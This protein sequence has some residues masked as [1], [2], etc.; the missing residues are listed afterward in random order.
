MR[1]LFFVSC[2]SRSALALAGLALLAGPAAAA[3]PVS[4][5]EATVLELRRALDSGATTSVEIVRESLLRIALYEDRLNAVIAVNPEALEEAAARD[6]ERAELAAAGRPVPLLHG[7]PVALKDNIHTLDL[8]TTGGALAFAGLVPPYEATL[9]ANLRAAGAIVLAKT[10]MTE[11]A[12]WIAAGMPTNYCALTGFGFNPYDPRRDPRE[13]TADGRPALWTGGSSSGVGTAVSFWVASVGTETSGS[14]LSP[15]GQ[16]L[17]AAVKPTVGRVSRYGIIPLTADQDTAG[18][19]ARTVTDAAI[20]LSALEG[21]APDPH[22]AET[23]RCPRP[24]GGDYTRFLDAGAL[25]GARIGIPR[26]Y[27][28]DEVTPPGE[29]EAIGGL[30]EGEAA[31]MKEAIEVLRALGAEVVDP[32]DIPSVV[33]ADRD[34]NALLWSVCRGPGQGKGRDADCSIVFKYGMKRDF[35]AWLASLGERAP[36][37][38]L[39]ALRQ[40]NVAH[41][42]MGAL[43]YGQAQLD[44]SDEMDVAL[45]RARYEMDRAKDLRLSRDEGIDAALAAHRLDALLFPDGTGAA[46]AAKAGYPTVMVPMGFVPNAPAPPFPPGFDARPSPFGVSF[47]GPACSEPRLLALAYAFEQA[48]RE[49]VPPPGFP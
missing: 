49:R 2:R 28:Y 42:K 7:L 14:I 45:D 4:V 15:A 37:P 29:K 40:W 46:I 34:A 48:T 23:G 38:T 39:T 31:L 10:Q 24:E 1:T 11:L 36:V 16:N 27:F 25:K 35:D 20:L 19:M 13:A 41:Q 43:R 32:A 3:P 12:N 47:T 17:L 21:A 44:I 22:D 6:R 30:D 26:A 9:V 8:P 18:P 5:V 33:A